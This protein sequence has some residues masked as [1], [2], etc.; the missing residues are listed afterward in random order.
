[1]QSS[2]IIEVP[3]QPGVYLRRVIV[4]ALDSAGRPPINSGGRL[5]AKQQEFWDAFQNGTGSPADDPNRPDRFPLA[6]VRFV[7]ADITP[8]ADRVRRLRAAGLVR[9]YAYEEWHWEVP[10]VYDY[11]LV[12]AIPVPDTT[13]IEHLGDP[14]SLRI[15]DSPFYRASHMAVIHNGSAA[16]SVPA[17]HVN[18]LTGQ[19][20]VDY[21]AYDDDNLLETEVRMVWQ[22]GGLS[23]ADAAAKTTE[24]IKAL[25]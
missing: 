16:M 3:W 15:I 4:E 11:D 13:T 1:M 12:H 17:G 20:R 10:N 8:T 25:G 9:P 14:M 22:L 2:D 23:T 24:M 5:K 19:G 21:V 18:A 7:A 6:H